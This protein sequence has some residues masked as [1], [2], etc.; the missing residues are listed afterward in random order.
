MIIWFSDDPETD[1]VMGDLIRRQSYQLPFLK[2]STEEKKL[3][4]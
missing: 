1:F 4:E 3:I 2:G